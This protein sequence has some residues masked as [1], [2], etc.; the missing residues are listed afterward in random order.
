MESE[1][2]VI[3]MSY[4]KPVEIEAGGEDHIPVMLYEQHRDAL[5]SRRLMLR[6]TDTWNRDRPRQVPIKTQASR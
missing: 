6:V 4:R 1:E 3:P 2:L 5:S